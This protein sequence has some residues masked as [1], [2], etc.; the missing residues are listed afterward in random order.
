[1]SDHFHDAARRHELVFGRSSRAAA[2]S[3]AGQALPLHMSSVVAA[4]VMSVSSARPQPVRS[5]AHREK[6][7]ETKANNGRSMN[8]ADR[9][10]L[11]PP[12]KYHHAPNTPKRRV[13][14]NTFKKEAT[15][16]PLLPGLVLGFPPVRGGQWGGGVYPTPF[17]KVRRHPQASPHR[18]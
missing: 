4:P 12:K 2:R 17:R 6:E 13:P 15:T 8:E 10:L 1:M 11:H 3:G 14:S 9:Q 16:T 5:N 18:G 7:R